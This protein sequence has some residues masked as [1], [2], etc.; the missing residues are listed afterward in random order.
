[1]SK[2]VVMGAGAVGAR[3]ARLLASERSLDAIVVVDNDFDRANEVAESIGSPVLALGLP[4]WPE[5]RRKRFEESCEDADVVM[6]CGEEDHVSFATI[7]LDAGAHVVSVADDADVVES[8]LSLQEYAQLKDRL[9]VVGA[10]FSPGLTCLLAIHAARD[11]DSVDEIHVAKTGT[12][13][14][15]CARAHHKAL[16][17]EARD[18]RNG[19]WETHPG[20]T[21][22]ELYWFPDPVGGLDCYYAELSEPLLLQQRFAQATRITARVSATRRDQATKWLPMMRSPHP[23]GLVGAIRVEVRGNIGDQRSVTILGVLDRPAIAAASMAVVVAI[24]ILSGNLKQ[25]GSLGVASLVEDSVPYL[26]ELKTRG[27]KAAVFDG[28]AVGGHHA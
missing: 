4:A 1:M 6:L 25:R 18:V 8:L 17:S 26:Q 24:Q 19:E 7:A 15:A 22:R 23:E 28:R 5:A 11:F 20:G 21:G 2:A 16:R 13:G 10:G 14:P 3:V 9:L 12:G 27:V